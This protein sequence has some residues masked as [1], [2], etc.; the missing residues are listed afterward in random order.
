MTHFRL[1]AFAPCGMMVAAMTTTLVIATRNAHKVREIRD[2]LGP[3]FDFLTLQAFPDAPA[4]VEDADTF[5]GNAGKKASELARWLERSPGVMARIPG[6]E[7]YVL[8]DDSGLEVDAL[9]GAPGVRS[10][11]FAA[12]ETMAGNSPDA[13][14]N[15]RLLQLLAEVPAEK[16]TARFRCVI[17]LAPVVEPPVQSA[18]P[19]CYAPEPDAPTKFFE[20]VC[21]GRIGFAPRGENGF[22]YDPLFVPNGFDQTFAELGDAVKRRISHRAVALQ[23]LK[24][25]LASRATG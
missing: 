14:N 16:R 10:A 19:V 18:S 21:E 7:W 8:A 15:A 17:A 22:G 2:I 3:G 6:S 5:A 1:A 23:R 25:R 4:V 20:G 11:R 24:D 13:A 9:N 12:T